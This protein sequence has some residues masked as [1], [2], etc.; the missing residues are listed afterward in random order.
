MMIWLYSVIALLAIGAMLTII[1]NEHY[2]FRTKSN[3]NPWR[4]VFKYNKTEKIIFRVGIL[5]IIVAVL[6]AV[7]LL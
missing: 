3:Y 6:L 4:D 7:V 5:L 2:R 1:A